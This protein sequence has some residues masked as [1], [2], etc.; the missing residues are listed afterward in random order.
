MNEPQDDTAAPGSEPNHI[1]VHTGESEFVIFGQSFSFPQTWKGVASTLIL[2]VT[3]VL[4]VYIVVNTSPDKLDRILSVFTSRVLVDTDGNTKTFQ[5]YQIGFWTPGPDTGLN[6][7]KQNIQLPDWQTDVSIEK[8]NEF[9]NKLHNAFGV[10]GWRNWEV[11]GHGT[12]TVKTGYWWVVAM[13]ESVELEDIAE[14]YREHW[15]ESMSSPVGKIYMEIYPGES[16]YRG[17]SN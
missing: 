17:E 3:I 7:A 10:N 8:M 14:L 11:S 2:C 15:G 5:T 4:T 12:S 16:G 9:G 13:K 1:H 6:A